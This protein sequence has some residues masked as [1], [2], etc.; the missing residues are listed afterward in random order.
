M[1]KIKNKKSKSDA[2]E[3]IIE[4]FLRTSGFVFPL[5]DGEL[6]GFEKNFGTTDI[7]LPPELNDTAFLYAK[8]K[9]SKIRKEKQF[10]NENFAMA[11]REGFKELPEEI[12]KK[13][14]NDIKK[15]EARRRKRGK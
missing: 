5:T 13:I 12:Q 7:I 1:K 10:L 11:A 4:K 3:R 14:I 2:Q 15:T 9:K 6:K 8:S